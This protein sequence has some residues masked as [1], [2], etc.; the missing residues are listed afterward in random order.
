M[1]KEAFNAIPGVIYK[2]KAKV[3]DKDFTVEKIEFLNDWVEKLTG[4]SKEDI[5]R[6]PGWWYQNIHP[7]D[8]E[9]VF[10]ECKRLSEGKDFIRR[11]YRFR[12]KD[13]SYM[14]I[15]DTVSVVECSDD[16]DIEIVGVWEDISQQEEYYEVFKAVDNAP[17]VG[18]IIYQDTIVYANQTALRAFGYTREELLEKKAYELVP[19]NHRDYIKEVVRRRLSG[20]QF[21]RVYTELP[22]L[23]KEG[24]VRIAYIFTRTI[25]WKGKPAGFVI[26]IDITK[27]KRYER[28]FQILKDINQLIITV[29]DED[30]LLKEIC[31]LLVEKAGF[32][33]VWVGVPD[34]ETGYVKP[35]K[36]C[37]DDGGYVSKI[38]I[39][40]DERTPEGRGPTGTALRE[41]QIIINPDTRTNPAVK[42]WREEMLKHGF[43]SSCAIPFQIRG[44]TVGVLNIYSAFPNMFREEELELL[45]EIQQDISFALERIEKEKFVKLINTAIEKG[46]EWV[47]ITD[48]EGNILYANRAVEEISGY[49]QDELIGQNPRIF[50][51]GYHSDE[52]YK[53]LWSTIKA[54]KTFQAVFVNK[55]K[56]GSLFY[57]DQTITPVGVGKGKVRF[58]AF[59]KDVTSEKYLEEEIAKLKYTDALTGLPNREGFLVAVDLNLAKDKDREHI[60]FLIDILDFSGINEVYGTNVGNEILKM[61]AGLLRNN[62]FERDI[63]GRIGGDEFAVL[64][65]GVSKKDVTTITHKLFSMFSKPFQIDGKLVKVNINV[66]AS[67]YPSDATTAQELLEK[68]S[69][70]LSFAKREGENTYRFFSKDITLMVKEH[71]R[72]RSDLEKALQEDR[73][74]L[75]FQPIYRLVDRKVVGLEALI[76]LKD[77]EGKI[78]TPK[79]FI[80]VL[81]KTGLIREVEDRLLEKLRDFILKLNR[82][83][84]VSFNVS[85]KSFKDEA[86]V[87]KVIEVSKDVRESM[88]LEITERLFVENPDYALEFLE[89]VRNLGVKV[90]I[91]DFGTGYSSLAYLETL[92]VDIIKIDMKFVHRMVHSDKS[93]AIV[94]TIVELARRLG[95]E[96]IAEGVE[97]EEQLRL[98]RLLGCNFVQGFLL[99]KPMPQEEAEKLLL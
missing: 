84:M 81:E 62:L 43:L 79:E 70:A 34:D 65:K 7:E 10:I 63:V 4:W 92:P 99:A 72:I 59:G 93:L 32:K 96:T 17:A 54:G 40:I 87:K 31:R 67:I 53:R 38:R 11:A 16:G 23:T 41:G 44:K 9:K 45:K 61:V 42:P 19:E 94:E 12:K 64:A 55:R 86:F 58:V 39:S 48:E 60:F 91:D 18:V 51:S 57:L 80:L 88:V 15:L 85:P 20:E 13:G 97:S 33:M 52:F 14:F 37:G 25:Q 90:A 56:D 75:F 22:V 82:K 6:D 46:H 66:G 27:Q 5:E 50:K 74:V 76:R 89:E 29:Y 2:A 36:V 21:D 49:S 77:R 35:L 83:V 24:N 30:E 26:F 28:M 1:D 8:R 69:T 73:F 78:H 98:L 95:M 3:R 47:I 68:A 71:F